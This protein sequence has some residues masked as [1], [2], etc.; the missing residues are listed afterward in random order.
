MI[1]GSFCVDLPLNQRV[2]A[3]VRETYPDGPGALFVQGSYGENE[4]EP[5]TLRVG[6]G[7]FNVSVHNFNSK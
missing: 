6:C 3:S 1:S 7:L 2:R 5:L 4:K